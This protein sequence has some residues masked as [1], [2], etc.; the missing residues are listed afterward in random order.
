MAISHIDSDLFGP[1]EDFISYSDSILHFQYWYQNFITP[2]GYIYLKTKLK[3]SICCIAAT[4]LS[5][6]FIL[7]NTNKIMSSRKFF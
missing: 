4:F 2:N 5:I 6:S 3:L 7:T 1:K